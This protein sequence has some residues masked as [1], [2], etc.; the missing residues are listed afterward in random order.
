VQ[1]RSKKTDQNV[2]RHLISFSHD[3]ISSRL[4]G[5]TQ[6]ATSASNKRAGTVS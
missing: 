5:D 3:G 2:A 4:R 1:A 6:L